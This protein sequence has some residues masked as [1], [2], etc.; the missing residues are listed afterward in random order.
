[1]FF[2]YEV[3]KLRKENIELEEKLKETQHLKSAYLNQLHDIK[4]YTHVL[5]L[6]IFELKGTLG[7]RDRKLKH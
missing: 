6:E 3:S 4:T 7:Q 1:M 2:V 5:K